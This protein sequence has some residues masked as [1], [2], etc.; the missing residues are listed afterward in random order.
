MPLFRDRYRVETVRLQG[1]DYAEAGMYFITVCTHGRY[2]WFGEIRNGLMGLSDAGCIVAQEITRTSRLRQNIILDE[3][4]VMPN[5]IHAIVEICPWGNADP[6]ITCRRNI[7]ADVAILIPLCRLRPSSLGSIVGNIKS[8]ST[9]RI[10]K[11][12]YPDFK[13]QSN[14]YD[15][16]IRSDRALE[17]IR[18]YIR[19]NPCKNDVH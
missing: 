2:P 15:R 18:S 7:S 11:A 6:V 14:F 9:S 19:N 13:W 3:W 12:G 5:H 10:W 8:A 4:V 17:N 16:I 1:R